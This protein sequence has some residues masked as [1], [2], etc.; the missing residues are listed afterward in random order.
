M[1]CLIFLFL[2][3]LLANAMSAQAITPI[4][5]LASSMVKQHKTGLVEV[6]VDLKTPSLSKRVKALKKATGIKPDAD[7]LKLLS[8]QLSAEQD[9]LMAQLLPIGATELTR[10][11]LTRNAVAVR[12]EANR[13]AQIEQLALVLQ[14]Q[15]I[16]HRMTNAPAQIPQGKE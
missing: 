13:I 1:R 3:G 14:V 2:I 12:V 15:Y 10:I 5:A 7:K 11:T 4:H 9:S 8:A 6:W 16:T